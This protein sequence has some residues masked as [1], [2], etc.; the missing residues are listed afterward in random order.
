MAN[1]QS[2]PEN[3]QCALEKN[4]SCCHQGECSVMSV[5]SRCSMMLRPLFPYLLSTLE[6]E[7]LKSPSVEELFTPPL[8]NVSCCFL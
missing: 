3:A 5:R 1:I 4:V 2:N 7:V 8:N 6:S